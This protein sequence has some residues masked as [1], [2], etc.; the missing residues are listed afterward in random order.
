MVGFF[1]PI[2]TSNW[3][4]YPAKLQ[5]SE[6]SWVIYKRNLC[7]AYCLL[8]CDWKCHILFTRNLYQASV[9][10]RLI[11]VH[12]H[13]LLSTRNCETIVTKSDPASMSDQLKCNGNDEM[14]QNGSCAFVEQ[15]ETDVLSGSSNERL[16]YQSSSRLKQWLNSELFVLRATR[17]QLQLRTRSSQ[18]G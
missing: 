16:V 6:E 1:S 17:A 12:W 11:S 18:K 10:P 4:T 8:R 2:P 15:G 13:F 3:F 14:S 9:G 7:P 5:R